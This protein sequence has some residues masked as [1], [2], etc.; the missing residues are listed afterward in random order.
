[1]C[2]WWIQTHQ[3]FEGSQYSSGDDAQKH[4]E[5]IEHHTGPQQT[6]Q[7]HHVPAAAHTRELIVPHPIVHAN[8]H[9]HTCSK[10][11]RNTAVLEM[12]R[13]WCV[14]HLLQWYKSQQ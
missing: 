5:H 9:T 1:M 12:L 3:V 2:L 10:T 6:V 11:L 4:S 13:D 8:T 7:I 14:L